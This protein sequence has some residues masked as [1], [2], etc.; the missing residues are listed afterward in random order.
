M[1]GGVKRGTG[2]FAR[3]MAVVLA[4]IL[5]LTVAIAAISFF[6]VRSDRIQSRLEALKSEA[7]E[8]AYLA[9]RTTAYT[10]AF[11]FGSDSAATRLLGWKAQQVYNEF[12]AYILVVDRRGVVRDNLYFAQSEDPDFT[13]SLNADELGDLMVRVLSGEELTIR[14]T[15][16][17]NPA[18]TVGVPFIQ[19][20]R[21][22]G[23]VLIRTKAQTIEN[24]AGQQ[25]LLIAIAAAAVVALAALALS[26]CLNPVLRPLREVTD[27]ARAMSDGDFSRRVEVASGTREIADLSAAFNGMAER[28]GDVEESRREFV[29][30]VSHE[31]RSPITS[32]SGFIGGMA[33][34]TIPP[35]EHPQ[36]L[37]LVYAETQRMAKLIGELLS[38]SRLERGAVELNL[39]EFDLCSLFRSVIVR[40]VNDLERK[41]MEVVCDFPDD[42]CPVRADRDRIEEVVINLVDNAIKFTPEGGCLTLRTRREGRTVTATVADNGI[43]ILPEDRP[44]VFD[45]FFTADR[46]HTAGKG[47][48][49]GLSIC[50]RIMEMHGQSI[51]L[52]E[53]PEGAAFEFTVEAVSG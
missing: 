30:N 40:R 36:Y 5:V 1:S 33:D 43:G 49:L 18:F 6:A 17:G 28:L 12:G 26:L 9:S 3:I 13:G 35:E 23:A 16:G 25:A 15:I 8:I 2:L 37:K 53:A 34:G 47:T 10:D 52:G 50:K 41:H 51:R 48:G 14:T 45:R 20:E 4:V 32:I 7:R 19:E 21:V 11:F 29:A 39:T 22:L 42:P 31:L 38:L 27:A 44:H 46:A 24:S